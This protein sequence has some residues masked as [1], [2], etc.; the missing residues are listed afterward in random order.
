VR[1]AANLP[2]TSA[3]RSIRFRQ[4]NSRFTVGFALS[5]GDGRRGGTVS[6]PIR[7]T[8]QPAKLAEWARESSIC[9]V[10]R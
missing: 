3:G 10:L 4:A 2:G 9:A 8:R 7:T 5:A 1:D 6:S